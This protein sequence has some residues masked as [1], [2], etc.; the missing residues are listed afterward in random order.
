MRPIDVARRFTDFLGY[1]LSQTDSLPEAL[2]AAELALQLEGEQK[3]RA[4]FD[5]AGCRE[6]LAILDGA[7]EDLQRELG[8]TIKDAAFSIVDRPAPRREP[9]PSDREPDVE[10]AYGSESPGRGWTCRGAGR[11][12]RPRGRDTRCSDTV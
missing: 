7:R 9:A 2:A 11:W 3:A 12:T 8:A 10:E 4:F 5:P 1:T 6:A